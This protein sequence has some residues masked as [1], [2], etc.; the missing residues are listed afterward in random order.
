MACSS[1]LEGLHQPPSAPPQG[2][3]KAN[4][5]GL[6]RPAL[7]PQEGARSTPQYA[8]LWGSGKVP[9]QVV[10]DATKAWDLRPWA[11]SWFP[12]VQATTPCREGEATREGGTPKGKASSPLETVHSSPPQGGRRQCLKPGP[13][14]SAEV[15][16]KGGYGFPLRSPEPT[17]ELAWGPP[18]LEGTEL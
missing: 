10:L 14:G 15:R 1:S 4:P 9:F 8:G 3:E 13:Q 11:P 2:L 6:Q 5:A 18:G 12:T 7:C 16:G 17:G